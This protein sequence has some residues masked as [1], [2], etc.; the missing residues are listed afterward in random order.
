[1]C[2]DLV[3][4]S[5]ATSGVVQEGRWLRWVWWALDAQRRAASD[6]SGLGGSPTV[7][8]A[9]WLVELMPLLLLVKGGDTIH[10]GAEIGSH[11]GGSP[12]TPWSE[13]GVG[14]QVSPS[15]QSFH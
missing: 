8:A 15:F 9:I 6:L 1:M 14:I 12:P 3:T 5:M 4:H 10:P 11:P 13:A 2:P 7:A